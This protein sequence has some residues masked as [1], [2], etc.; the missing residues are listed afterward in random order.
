MRLRDERRARRALEAM[1]RLSPE[2]REKAVAA[3]HALA[4]ACASEAGSE[5]APR[6]PYSSRSARGK[7]VSRSETSTI[8]MDHPSCELRDPLSYRGNPRTL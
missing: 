1:A 3:L 5:A 4:Q 8:A 7:S 6:D 2:A